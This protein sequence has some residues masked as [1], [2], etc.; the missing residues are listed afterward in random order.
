MTS[1]EMEAT[2]FRLKLTL[3]SLITQ[4][5]WNHKTMETVQKNCKSKHLSIDKEAFTEKKT[6]IRT[7]E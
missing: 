4:L 6:K 2:E 7:P 1:E 3:Q 5:V